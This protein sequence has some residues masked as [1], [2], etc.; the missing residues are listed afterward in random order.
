MVE[1]VCVGRLEG[2]EPLMVGRTWCV[3]AKLFE[4]VGHLLLFHFFN[5]LADAHLLSF[6]RFFLFKR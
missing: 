2:C 4:L 6:F 3:A 1:L 5:Q